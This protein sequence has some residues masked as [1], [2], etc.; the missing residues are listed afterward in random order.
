MLAKLE[1]ALYVAFTTDL[2]TSL[3]NIAY[4]CVT[5][6][7]INPVDSGRHTGQNISVRLSDC[8]SE[9]NIPINKIAATVHDNG[10]N[11]NAAMNLLDDWPDQL[12]F[13]HTLQLAI[14]AGLKVK[15]IA[16]MLGAS[17]RLSTHFKCSTVAAQAL[18]E[19]QKALQNNDTT[20][21]SEVIIDCS[22][23]WNST[24]DMLERLIKLWWAIGAVLSDPQVTVRS[25]A[26]T[27]EMTDENWSLAEALIP[28]LKPFKQVTVMS[29]G[30]NYPSILSVYVHLYI[31]MK[32]I[33]DLKPDDAA[34]IKECR[35]AIT[36]ELQTLYYP[37]GY[38]VLN[39]AKA[40][41]VDPR[42]KLLKFF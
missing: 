33:S 10:S 31:I 37:T 30:Q 5:A 42:Y 36:N 23:R 17:R 35:K 39:A 21:V 34:A 19:K 4:M 41:V 3:Q 6:H 29:S 1:M 38:S 26:S 14:S 7:W 40:A 9:W 27:F 25:I 32:N 13:A 15:S 22:T 8:A 2:W 12:C 24:L 16:R 18:R 11:M 20:M 28:I